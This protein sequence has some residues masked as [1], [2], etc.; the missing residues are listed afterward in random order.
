MSKRI[1]KSRNVIVTERPAHPR[2]VAQEVADFVTARWPEC[3]LGDSLI[4]EGLLLAMQMVG[5]PSGA[6]N[7]I[8]YCT[9]KLS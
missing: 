6:A 9:P 1:K 7:V 8:G 4:V 2:I 5:G 3:A